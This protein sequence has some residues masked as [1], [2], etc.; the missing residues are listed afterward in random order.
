ME[1]VHSNSIKYKCLVVIASMEQCSLYTIDA[2]EKLYAN[3]INNNDTFIGVN[4]KDDEH[5]QRLWDLIEDIKLNG[6]KQ[7]DPFDF[8]GKV[9]IIGYVE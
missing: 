8:N 1:L 6:N 4:T 9:F 2:D 3:L 7:V 5:D